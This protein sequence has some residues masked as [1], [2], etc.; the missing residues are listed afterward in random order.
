MSHPQF[1][2]LVTIVDASGTTYRMLPMTGEKVPRKEAQSLAD[3]AFDLYPTAVK[4]QVVETLI[5]IKRK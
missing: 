3:K 1:Q 2:A 4:A 5:E